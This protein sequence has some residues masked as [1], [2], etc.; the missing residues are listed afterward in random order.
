MADWNPSEIIGNNPNLLDYS[1]YNYLLLE[2]EWREGRKCIGYDDV[3][4]H[5]LMFKFGNKPFIDVIASFKSM[6]PSV[7][8]S[9]LK[10]KLLKTK[11]SLLRVL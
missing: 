3:S 5:S 6:T 9:S 8:N 11:I 7:L 4:P 1:L 10:Q 2:T